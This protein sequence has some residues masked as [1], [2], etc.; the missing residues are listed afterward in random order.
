MSSSSSFQHS[1]K[2]IAV[3]KN[4]RFENVINSLIRIT[5]TKF[6]CEL[7]GK[8]KQTVDCIFK[9]AFEKPKSMLLMRNIAFNRANKSY[10]TSNPMVMNKIVNK[11]VDDRSEKE[12]QSATYAAACM[13]SI[14]SNNEKGKAV[15][16][17]A[18]IQ[19]KIAQAKR[20]TEES[21]QFGR[22]K[23]WQHYRL[24]CLQAITL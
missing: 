8:H 12:L 1:R 5:T 16:K 9:R 20:R 15:L 17:H 21:I 13:Y 6:G 10:F 4:K 23:Q 2:E 18:D 11:L 22:S 7:I 3:D 19:G 14:I 24:K